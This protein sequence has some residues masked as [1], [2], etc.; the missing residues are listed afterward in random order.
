MLSK[1]GRYFGNVF[2]LFCGV[3]FLAW[4][5]SPDPKFNPASFEDAPFDRSLVDPT[6]A[7]TLA[8]YLDP[9]GEIVTLMVV[10]YDGET[11]QGIN[12]A[13]SFAE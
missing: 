12:L 6:E 7:I 5:T 8:Q 11:V 3:T 1:L 2:L 4:L 10:A 9:I 13:R